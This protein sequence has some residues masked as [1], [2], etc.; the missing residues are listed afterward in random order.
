MKLQI[1]S[2]R[3]KRIIQSIIDHQKVID[4]EMNNYSEEFRNHDLIARYE[5]NIKKLQGY[6]EQNFIEV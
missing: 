6:L 4:N 2:E 1:T 5:A 3:K